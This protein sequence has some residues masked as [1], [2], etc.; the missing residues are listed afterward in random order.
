MSLLMNTEAASE[1]QAAVSTFLQTPLC[2]GGLFLLGTQRPGSE[3]VRV[4]SMLI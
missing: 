4:K 3:T 1:L 2:T